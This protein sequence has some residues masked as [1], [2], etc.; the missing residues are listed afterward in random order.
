LPTMTSLVAHVLA[1]PWPPS[2]AAVIVSAYY[3]SLVEEH[4]SASLD[5]LLF[6]LLHTMLPVP[7]VP[8]SCVQG[9]C[10]TCPLP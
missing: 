10:W 6:D 2:V 1:M 5:M 3:A 7:A 9:V 4:S 8:C